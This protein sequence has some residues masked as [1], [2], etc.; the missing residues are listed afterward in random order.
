MLRTPDNRSAALAKRVA[1]RLPV[2]HGHD[3]SLT[4]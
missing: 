2:N 1:E 3:Q 4:E